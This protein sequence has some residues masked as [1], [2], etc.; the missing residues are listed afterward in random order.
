[1]TLAGVL[2]DGGATGVA[3]AHEAS[4]T[5]NSA[6]VVEHADM[7]TEELRSAEAHRADALACRRPRVRTGS[8]LAMTT[9][10]S[11]TMAAMSESQRVTPAG[12]TSASRAR[13]SAPSPRLPHEDRGS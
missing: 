9:S 3:G 4:A 6:V 2:V 11:S 8:G 10:S 12:A 13:R 5:V 7:L 1:M